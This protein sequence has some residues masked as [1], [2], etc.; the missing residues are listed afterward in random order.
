MTEPP[1]KD[2]RRGLLDAAAACESVVIEAK[3][4]PHYEIYNRAVLH[5]V[6]AIRALMVADTEMP[7]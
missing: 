1:K 4:N 3:N 2:Y 7:S 5:C 6:E